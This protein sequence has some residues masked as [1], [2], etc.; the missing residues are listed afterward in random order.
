V[1]VGELSYSRRD[2]FIPKK[3]GTRSMDRRL[4]GLQMRLD[5]LVKINIFIF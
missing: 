2:R 5:V 3:I 4:G 1:E